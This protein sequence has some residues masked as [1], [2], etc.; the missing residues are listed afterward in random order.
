MMAYQFHWNNLFTSY[1]RTLKLSTQKKTDGAEQ[2]FSGF[3]LLT[4]ESGTAKETEAYDCYLKPK[5]QGGVSRT[6]AI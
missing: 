5:K 4:P 6:K 2:K 3:F 1:L